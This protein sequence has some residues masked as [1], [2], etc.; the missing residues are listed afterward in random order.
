ME[1]ELY[2]I[3]VECP[4]IENSSRFLGEE[5][6]NPH[7]FPSLNI[8]KRAIDADIMDIIE[9]GCHTG[10]NLRYEVVPWFE[11]DIG[12]PVWVVEKSGF[13]YRKYEPEN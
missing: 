12:E 1:K 10:Y 6:K 4:E 9:M 8:A 5:D 3:I 7:I 11:T 2:A 13:R